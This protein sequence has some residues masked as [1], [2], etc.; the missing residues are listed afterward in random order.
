MAYLIGTAGHVDH[1]KTTLIKVLTG[2]DADRLPEEKERGMTIDVGFAFIDFPNAGRV[3]IVDVPGHERFIKNMLAGASG[4]DIALL[5]VAA[6]ESVMPQTA[7]HFQIL[8]LLQAKSLIVAHT[9]SDLVDETALADSKTKIRE[10]LS[11]SIYEASP[12]VEVSSTTGT[13]IEKLRQLLEATILS[14]PQQE[15]DDTW[16]MPIDRVF[17]IQGHGTI[18]TGT[19]ANGKVSSNEKAELMPGSHEVR[20]RSIQIHGVDSAFAEKGQRC[21]LNISGAK[22]EE[23]HRGQ[24]IGSSHALIETQ[25]FNFNLI[26]VAPIK[27]GERIRV[28]IGAGEFIGK[29]FLFDANPTLA[30]VRLEVPVACAKGQRLIFR[31][32]SPPVLL[33]G[34]EITAPLALPNKKSQEISSEEGNSILEV[35]DAAPEGIETEAICR[36]IGRTSQQ[37]GDEFEKIKYAGDAFGFAGIW[38]DKKHYSS[39]AEKVRLKLLSL[40]KE[41]PQA[42]LIPKSKL[43]L[44]MPLVWTGKP[45]DRLLSKMND[46]G[47]IRMSGGE[48]RHP[49][50]EIQLSEKQHSLLEKVLEA[51]HAGKA[52]APNLEALAANAGAPIP[53]IQEMLRLGVETGRIVKVDHDLYYSQETLMELEKA[54]R[55][56]APRFTVA[57]FRDLTGSSRKYALPLLQYFDEKHVT[58]R[59]EE[60]RVV[61]E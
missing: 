35:L 26:G 6:N 56:L 5:C 55:S 53:A 18:V 31:K 37:L 47:L 33:G 11:G 27:H 42:S 12:I 34:G 13:G 22:K 51:M 52:I 21:A 61:L 48:L 49:N 30:Q 50:H 9:K 41:M 25:C 4:I 45:L 38:V 28:H 54:V 59:V 32:Y 44:L 24:A 46:D 60:D 29:I 39:L 19:V 2:I 1:G 3:G 20:I 58:R 23:L 16:F 7:E 15:L 43:A 36:K 17:T 57:Q 10:L 14:L 8:K 40:H